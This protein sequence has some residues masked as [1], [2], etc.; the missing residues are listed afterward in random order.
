MTKA[1]ITRDQGKKKEISN[2]VIAA[3]EKPYSGTS[4]SQCNLSVLI[5]VCSTWLQRAED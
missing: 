1:A 2:N 4:L 5:Q 3:E